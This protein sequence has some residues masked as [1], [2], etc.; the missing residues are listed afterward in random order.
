MQKVA[1]EICVSLVAPSGSEHP[2]WNSILPAAPA[3]VR[4]NILFLAQR[5]LGVPSSR[6]PA[7]VVT[8]LV[9]LTQATANQSAG[10]EP[11]SYVPACVALATDA[12][13]LLL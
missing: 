11:I 10:L 1:E 4:S 2:G 6:V 8:D 9:A 12:E 13:A 5:F 7:D 3:S